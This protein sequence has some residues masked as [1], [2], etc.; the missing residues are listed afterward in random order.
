M[1]GTENRENYG[2]TE[3]GKASSSET[4]N[5]T[6]DGTASLVRRNQI[7]EQ[8][9]WKQPPCSNIRMSS[10]GEYVVLLDIIK[11]SGM[12]ASMVTMVWKMDQHLV[13]KHRLV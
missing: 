7:L 5:G 9:A 13:L 1:M 11:M 3:D 12:N 6:K 10:K 2:H 8:M 4:T